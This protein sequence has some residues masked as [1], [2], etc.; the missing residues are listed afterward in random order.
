MNDGWRRGRG[1]KS[2]KGGARK[3]KRRREEQ[4]AGKEMEGRGAN[5]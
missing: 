1:K 4:S 5:R 2:R 3:E